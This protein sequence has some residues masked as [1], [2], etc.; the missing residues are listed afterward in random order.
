VTNPFY[1]N[2]IKKVSKKSLKKLTSKFTKEGGFKKQFFV[3]PNNLTYSYS[4]EAD[5]RISLLIDNGIHIG[6]PKLFSYK[7]MHK[8]IIG[9][10]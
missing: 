1:S 3:K 2:K 5:I 6:R 8:F 10:F 9:K 4:V 7:K